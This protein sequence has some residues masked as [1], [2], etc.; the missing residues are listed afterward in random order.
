[1]DVC[2]DVCV[3]VFVCVSFSYHNLGDLFSLISWYYLKTLIYL[4]LYNCSTIY[5]T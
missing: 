2:V 1:V 5:N 4:F 3:R